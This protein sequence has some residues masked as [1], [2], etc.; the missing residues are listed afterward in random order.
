MNQSVETIGDRIKLVRAGTSRAL[1]SEQLG[2]G[3]TT[4]QRYETNERLPDSDFIFKFCRYSQKSSDWLLFGVEQSILTP[5]EQLLISAYKSLSPQAKQTLL[6]SALTGQQGTTPNVANTINNTGT[7]D[8][9]NAKK[10]VINKGQVQN[11]NFKGGFG[12]DYVNG[13][14]HGK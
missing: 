12:G 9:F 4:L 13:D 8:Q 7:G 10:Q 6:T 11:N 2:V 14:K 5:D 3:T 1:F